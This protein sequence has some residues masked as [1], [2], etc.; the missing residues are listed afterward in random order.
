MKKSR[1]PEGKKGRINFIT[2]LD[3]KETSGGWTGINQQLFLNLSEHFEINYTG[4][5]SPPSD[6][7]AKFVSKLKRIAGRQGAFHFFS[8]RRL[9]RIADEILELADPAADYDFFH[10]QTPWIEYKSPRPYGVYIDACFATY[11]DIYHSQSRFLESDIKRI[12][13]LEARWLSNA[14]NVFFGSKWAMEETLRIYSIPKSPCQ[15]VGIAG[16]VPI[17]KADAYAN[18]L[19]FLFI[20]LDFERKGGRLCF[21]AFN[22]V[23]QEF[24]S[25]RL[26]ILGE[27]PP[28]DVLATPHVSYAGY[29][30]KTIAAEFELLQEFFM[31]AFALVHPT[32]M[33][34]MGMV[35]IEAGY[36]G[37]PAIAP[38]SFGI[39]E[40]V[41]DGITGL[42]IEPPPS[43]DAIAE[44]MLRLCRNPELYSRMR[45]AV[46]E[47]TSTMLTWNAV[48]DRIAKSIH[49]SSGAKKKKQRE[50]LTLAESLA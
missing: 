17:P 45:K 13:D 8:R 38:R 4:P 47:H 32:S 22:R 6:Y 2:N 30:R 3:L 21:E 39:P 26:I 40:L 18:E 35:L 9:L 15:V 11:L 24:P 42:L 50:E 43:I 5:I 41:M 25:A 16:N 49:E 48:V 20:A 23:R 14:R 33:D 31:R 19:N 34:T 46:K 1:K 36:F 28:G 29:L 37:C 7:P 10:G 44:S 12:C 27:K